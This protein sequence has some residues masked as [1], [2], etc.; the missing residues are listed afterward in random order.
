MDY[1]TLILN[2]GDHG[3][4]GE[5]NTDIIFLRALCVLRG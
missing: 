1:R 5:V 4:H 3:V 2:H